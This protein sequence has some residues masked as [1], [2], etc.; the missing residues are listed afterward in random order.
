MARHARFRV[1]GGWYHVFTRGHN[2]EA[3]FGN[4]EDC[5]HFLEL[6]ERMREL[7]GIRVHAYAV[8]SNHYHLL[9]T[10]PE[11][12]VSRAIQWL[13]GSYGTWYNRR[14]AR[15]GHVFGERFRAV[16]LENGARGLEVSTYIHMNPVAT[17]AFGLGK[18]QKAT[19]H[20]LPRHLAT[21]PAPRE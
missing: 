12:N 8:M 1:A 13:N 11:A 18:R 5:E 7:Y 10:T 3:V 2:R 4:E 19:Q 14:H 20:S 16:V 15:G 9:V 21:S 17:S 6:V